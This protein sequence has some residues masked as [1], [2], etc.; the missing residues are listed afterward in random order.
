M[1]CSS[2]TVWTM[3]L[4]ICKAAAAALTEQACLQGPVVDGGSQTRC[5]SV[6]QE[7]IYRLEARVTCSSYSAWKAMLRLAQ[8]THRIPRKLAGRQSPR[9]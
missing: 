9:V 2:I 8:A 4:D 6:A 1:T 7:I 5:S 3:I